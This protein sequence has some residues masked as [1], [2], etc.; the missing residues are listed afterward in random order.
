[1]EFSK[2]GEELRKAQVDVVGDEEYEQPRWFIWH[3]NQ[4]VQAPAGRNEELLLL[5]QQAKTL[6]RELGS[7]QPGEGS[8]CRTWECPDCG[9]TI[10]HSYEALAEV[11]VAICCDCDIEMELQ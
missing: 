5:D 6:R 11:G 10:E 9:R 7:S 3:N 2:Y 4:W 8:Y 1:V